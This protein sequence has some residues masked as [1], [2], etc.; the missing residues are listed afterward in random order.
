MLNK[1]AHE[2]IKKN[3]QIFLKMYPIFRNSKHDLYVMYDLTCNYQGGKVLPGLRSG[4]HRP[5]Y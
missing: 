3:V 5:S 1:T 2:K 4:S